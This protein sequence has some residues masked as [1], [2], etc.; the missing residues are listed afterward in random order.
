MFLIRAA[1]W[2]TI[3]ILL[4]PADPPSSE[5]NPQVDA[6]QAIGAARDTVADVSS[7][8]DRNPDACVTGNAVFDLLARKVRF[9]VR[10]VTEYFESTGQAHQQPG[11]D[12]TLTD[13]DAA[14]PWHP[15]K[16]RPRAT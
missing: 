15:P 4:L 1:F 16:Q 7:F 12:G 14:Q 11:Q 2:L 13:E 8:C 6:F 3:V 9:G 5:T 10:K